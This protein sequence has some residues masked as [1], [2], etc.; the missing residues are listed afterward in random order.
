MVYLQEEL[1][2]D[3]QRIVTETSDHANQVL[4]N[5]SVKPVNRNYGGNIIMPLC[6]C[7]NEIYMYDSVCVCVCVCVCL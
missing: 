7:A 1:I 6:A 4:F 3:M 5:P 2:D